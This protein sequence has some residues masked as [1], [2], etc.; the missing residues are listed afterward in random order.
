MRTTKWTTNTYDS[1][2]SLRLTDFPA[3]LP[4]Y[5]DVTIILNV[6]R[7]RYSRGGKGIHR[8]VLRA[9]GESLLQLFRRRCPG[10]CTGNSVWSANQRK[11]I[12]TNTSE[13]SLAAE[14]E[15]FR[16]LKIHKSLSKPKKKA[17]YCSH[18]PG[19]LANRV[20]TQ[21]PRRYWRTTQGR[22]TKKI[23]GQ[24]NTTAL[25]KSCS[26]TLGLGGT[27]GGHRNTSYEKFRGNTA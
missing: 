11:G 3:P 8:G 18:K 25:E 26:R 17:K 5:L 10:D 24:T 1:K 6:Q 15:C 19:V 9:A 13:P 4:L 12:T 7:W 22:E 23:T 20:I 27:F 16:P 14:T 21:L 2:F